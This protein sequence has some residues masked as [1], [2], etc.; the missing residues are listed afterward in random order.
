MA[1]P[2]SIPTQRKRGATAKP[3]LRS[4]APVLDPRRQCRKPAF[5]EG[6]KTL[7]KPRQL[8]ASVAKHVTRHCRILLVSKSTGV[9]GWKLVDNVELH[10]VPSVSKML[11]FLPCTSIWIYWRKHKVEF[12]V[13]S[14]AAPGN[15]ER[16][17]LLIRRITVAFEE[18]VFSWSKHSQFF[19]LHD[20]NKRDAASVIVIGALL[21]LTL[22]V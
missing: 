22:L 11:S 17:H 2:S 1:R 5:S 13:V 4:T 18:L 7:Y 10:G 3:S 14:G 9:L 15:L 19:F 20:G 6:V 21:S 12:C 8:C 16:L